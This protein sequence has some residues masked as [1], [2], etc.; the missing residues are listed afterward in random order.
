MDSNPSNT[1]ESM[2]KADDYGMEFSQ[3]EEEQPENQEPDE[4][5]LQ[6]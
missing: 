5:L 2:A 3:H 4:E 6:L 1:S